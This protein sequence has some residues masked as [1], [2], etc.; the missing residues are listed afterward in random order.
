MQGF[1]KCSCGCRSSARTDAGLMPLIQARVRL[2]QPSPAPRF[3]EEADSRE[4][5]LAVRARGA[6]ALVHA[7]GGE[8]CRA[9]VSRREAED[10]ARRRRHVA[11]RR[12]LTA[13]CRSFILT[14][15]GRA[16]RFAGRRRHPSRA[17]SFR[18]WGA[19]KRPEFE[20]ELR[21]GAVD[22]KARLSCSAFGVDHAHSIGAA[23]KLPSCRPFVLTTPAMTRPGPPAESRVAWRR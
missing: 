18:A 17:H 15:W 5:T 19:K 22:S 12:R 14:G 10:V 20:T 4:L 23:E 8:R 13:R 1:S 3:V 11:W 7:A 2:L 21:Q 9:D 16:G 6:R